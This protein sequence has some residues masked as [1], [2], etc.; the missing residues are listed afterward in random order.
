MEKGYRHGEICFRVIKKLSEG[1]TA[2]K[3]KVFLK[4]SHGNPHKFDKGTLYLKEVDE[5]IFG[6]FEAKGTTLSH[7]E[8]GQKVNKLKEKRAILPDG[9]YELRRQNEI[10]N[11]ELKP[12]KD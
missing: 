4:G 2:T 3:Q 7:I 10:V 12:V 6:Y 8:H 5:F 1:L 9:I 11:E